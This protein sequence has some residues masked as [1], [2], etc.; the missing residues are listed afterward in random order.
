M[1]L[2]EKGY[3]FATLCLGLYAAVSL[4]KSVRDRTEGIPVSNLYHGISWVALSISVLLVVVGLWN[5]ELALS[6]KGFYGIAFSLSLFAVISI[7]KNVRDLAQY[8][9]YYDG[10]YEMDGID[11]DM[12]ESKRQFF[13]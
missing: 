4:Q 11:N 7:Q 6:E 9:V 5:A 3:Y 13:K 12:D 1:Q 10:S 2:N 8:N